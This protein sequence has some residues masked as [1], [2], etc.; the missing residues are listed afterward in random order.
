MDK[1]AVEN[2]HDGMLRLVLILAAWLSLV[3]SHVA[4]T[5]HELRMSDNT[6]HHMALYEEGHSGSTAVLCDD[7]SDCNVGVSLCKAVCAGLPVPFPVLADASQY[8]PRTDVYVAGP[9]ADFRETLPDE[10]SRPPISSLL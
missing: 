2:Y 7:Q 5:A 9:G 6:D 1:V 8:A 4:A 3:L 10:D